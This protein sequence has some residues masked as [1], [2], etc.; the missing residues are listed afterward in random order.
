MVLL[1]NIVMVIK[2]LI[3]ISISKSIQNDTFS[4]DLHL[5]KILHH[6]HDNLVKNK[7][8]YY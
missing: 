5:W 1:M 4:K 7:C 8:S 6:D 2:S 3:S